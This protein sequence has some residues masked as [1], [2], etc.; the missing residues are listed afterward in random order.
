MH[1]L[2]A[3][4]SEHFRQLNALRSLTRAI[5]S[6]ILFAIFKCFCSLSGPECFPQFILG[7]VCSHWRDLIN[8]SPSF[9]KTIDIQIRN[10]QKAESLLQT[11]KERNGATFEFIQLEFE[12]SHD[13]Y[14]P[15]QRFLQSMRGVSGLE[16][17]AVTN[18]PVALLQIIS[19]DLDTRDVSLTGLPYTIKLEST[20]DFSLPWLALTILKLSR[21]RINICF[22]LLLGCP[23]LT[24]F[25]CYDPSEPPMAC[26]RPRV[27]HTRETSFPRLEYLMWYHIWTDWDH[28]FLSLYRFP[29]LRHFNWC[30]GEHYYSFE[31]FHNFTSSLPQ[32]CL[33]LQLSCTTIYD[34]KLDRECL[35]QIKHPIE[36]LIFSE[37]DIS[38][39]YIAL[40]L[41]EDISFVPSLVS[42]KW[43]H[44]HVCYL[45]EE[46]IHGLTQLLRNV[47]H[48]RREMGVGGFRMEIGGLRFR[49]TQ[50]EHQ[51]KRVYEYVSG[52]GFHFETAANGYWIMSF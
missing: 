24:Q 29:V 38:D 23:N 2:R 52:S 47:L 25:S 31:L 11:F 30:G 8:G 49:P 44:R 28:N 20:P 32:A 1:S 51:I 34:A 40:D 33:V 48:N 19:R 4:K 18:A 12:R 45:S 26:W 5:P 17:I 46:K 9:W 7:G 14:S 21:V 43:E 6:E 22:D 13:A 27:P 39:L 3:L 37:F 50:D 36:H 16:R 41:L 35:L 42:F 10:F 15:F